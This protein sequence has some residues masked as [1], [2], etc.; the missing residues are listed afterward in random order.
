ME[1]SMNL[2]KIL[3]AAAALALSSPGALAAPAKELPLRDFFRNPEQ[4]AHQISPNG[5][6]ISWLAPH[7]RR[8][9]VFVRSYDGGDAT[10]VTSDPARDIAG[11][12]WK[13]DRILFAKDFGGDENFH[14]V[15]VDLKGGD[16]KDLTPGEKVRANIVDG[17]YDDDTSIIVSHNR[18]DPKVF[19]VFRV[20][21]AS[22]EEKLV[23]QNPGNSG[24]WGTDQDGKL[25]I[26]VSTDGVNQSL[27]YREK[28][29]D[30]FKPIVTTNFREQVT[31]LFFTFDNKRMYVASNRGRDKTAIFL[32]DPVTARES[33]MLFEHP[34]VDVAGLNYSRKRKVLTSITWTTWKL[35]RKFLDKE[36]EAR[37]ND[38]Q[39]KLPGYE[40]AFTS[41]N[42]A[43]D[44][45]V[46]AS[47][48]DKTRGKRYLYDAKTGKL[49]FLSDIS[50]WLPE[51]ELADM[52]PVKYTSRDGLTINGYLTLPKGAAPK[53]LPVVVNPHGGPWARDR[54]G[55]NP[56]VQF[57]ANRGYAVLQMNFRGST[58]YGRKFWEASFKQWGGTMQD[59][60]TDGV[61]WV[62][63][64][65]IGD[66]KRVAIYGG[67]Y[68]G[69]AVLEGLV[70][71]P[72]LY[73][74]GG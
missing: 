12:F 32:F 10:R 39:S 21:V 2:L 28:E 50:P 68:G 17:L 67:S 33:E 35:D 20:N 38:V 53:N 36:S 42:R 70:K 27:L 16:L 19:D 45:F 52:K 62:I 65:G 4:A 48:N 60:I 18:R 25:R 22:G 41:T 46:V 23:A 74:A 5:R 14:I 37:F 8:L 63:Q 72:D 40:V 64:Q 61:N 73:A 43:E 56:E 71:T 3:V 69:Y 1:N 29:G 34:E 49:D 9:N 47:S 51:G 15:S 66:P 58:G 54:W 13:G 11:Y 59:D 6:Y 30:A 26:A 57:L 24:G 7:E 55:F 31:P 44:R